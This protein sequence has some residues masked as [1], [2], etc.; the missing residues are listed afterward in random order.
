MTPF[1][2]LWPVA[3]GRSEVMPVDLSKS[4]ALASE[5]SEVSISSILGLDAAQ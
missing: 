1:I 5:E 2:A 4:G 3:W